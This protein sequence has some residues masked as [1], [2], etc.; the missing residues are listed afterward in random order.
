MKEAR[1]DER[2]LDETH[3]HLKEFLSYLP[4]VSAESARGEVLISVS[5][6]DELLRRTLMAFFVEQKKHSELL[7]GANAPLGSFSSRIGVCEA[8]GLISDREARELHR[9]RKIRNRFSHEVYVSFEDQQI[10]DWCKALD[11][12]APDYGDVVVPPRGQFGSATHS[13][14]LNLV[15]RASYVSKERRAAKAWPY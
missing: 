12:K 3:P 8:L 14:I 11:Y 10:K 15:N 6:L 9:M 7:D 4:V 5:Y 2:S 13:L 1:L